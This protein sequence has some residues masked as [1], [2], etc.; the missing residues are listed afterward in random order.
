MII[1]CEAHGRLRCSECAYVDELKSEL[2]QLKKDHI[3]YISK[4]AKMLTEKNYEISNAKK[5]RNELRKALE[6]IADT[7]NCFE[8]L[9]EY[10]RKVLGKEKPN[11]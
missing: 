11:E 1:I 5:Q 10:A 9:P 8:N 4:M 6:Y 2:D 7:D 3:D